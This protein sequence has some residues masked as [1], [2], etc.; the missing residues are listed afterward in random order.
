MARRITGMSRSPA[1]STGTP[2]WNNLNGSNP[3]VYFDGDAVTFNDTSANKTVNLNTTVSPSSVTFNTASAYTL[4]GRA[5][6][7]PASAQCSASAAADPVALL[8]RQL[9]HLAPPPSPAP[10]PRSSSTTSRNRRNSKQ[11]HRFGQLQCHPRRRLRA[12]M[13]T[14]A[15]PPRRPIAE[16]PSPRTAA[17]STSP[18]TAGVALYAEYGVFTMSGSGS[19]IADPHRQRSAPKPHRPSAPPSANP[20]TGATSVVMNGRRQHSAQRRQHLFRRDDD[21][22]R[23]SPHRQ[24]RA[25]SAAA[26]GHCSPAARRLTSTR[27]ARVCKQFQPCRHRPDRRQ[28]DLQRR[29]RCVL[30]PTASLS[31]A[32]SR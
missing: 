27:P 13:M 1:F 26:R 8:D 17:R 22:Q 14:G 23:A 15:A 24:R 29:A 18:P 32:R 21:Q 2:N 19:R 28:S 9:L 3:D 25:H 12:E 30:R 5:A 16:S 31:P 11:Q 4:T 20:A 6:R 10:G 7:S